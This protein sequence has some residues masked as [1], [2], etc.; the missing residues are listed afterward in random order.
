[1]VIATTKLLPHNSK[2]QRGLLTDCVENE[3]EMREFKPDFK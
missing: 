3:S 2:I 1:M